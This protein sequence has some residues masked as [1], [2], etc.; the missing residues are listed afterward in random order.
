MAPAMKLP[1][2]ARKASA[3]KIGIF[4]PPAC[5]LGI[6]CLSLCPLI[7]PSCRPAARLESGYRGIAIYSNQGTLPRISLPYL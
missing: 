6:C 1:Q 4:S 2:K 7:S 5:H 3:S